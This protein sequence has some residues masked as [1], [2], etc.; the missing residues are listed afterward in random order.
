LP[1]KELLTTQQ[2]L[3]VAATSCFHLVSANSIAKVR[4]SIPKRRIQLQMGQIQLPMGQIQLQYT[5]K[6]QSLCHSDNRGV[7]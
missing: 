5:L 2:G 1:Y 4:N 3:V 6:E 7:G